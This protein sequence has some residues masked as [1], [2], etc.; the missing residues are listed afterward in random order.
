MF[1]GSALV[2]LI[3]IVL[4]PLYINHVNNR[5]AKK[6]KADLLTGFVEMLHYLTSNLRAGYSLEN[7]FIETR[8]N[9]ILELNEDNPIIN[10][11]NIIVSKLKINIS[12]EEILYDFALKCNNEDIST[13]VDVFNYSKRSGGNMVKII[14]NTENIIR[15]KVDLKRD[16]D[17]LIAGKKLEFRIMCLIPFF[18]IAYMRIS[19]S[20]FLDSLYGNMFGIIVM[21]I[22]LGLIIISYY[23]GNKIVDIK[24]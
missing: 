9:L 14:Q 6:Q 1:Y 15:E 21:S 5:K 18:I 17:L 23:L 16:I 20:K 11:I 2:G 19:F 24:I 13:F 3:G 7:S 22:S 4:L 12:I 10:E 8:K